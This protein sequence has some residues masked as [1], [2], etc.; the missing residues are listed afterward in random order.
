MSYLD[1]LAET[2]DSPM[3]KLDGLDECVI[4]V[5]DGVEPVFV[6]DVD[7]IITVLGRDMDYDE[8]VEY[9]DFNIGSAYYGPGTPSFIYTRIMEN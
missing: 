7:K 9:Y 8:A 5:T 1:E 6:Y 3:I 2:F 4:G